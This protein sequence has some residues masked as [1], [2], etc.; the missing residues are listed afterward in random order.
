MQK[1]IAHIDMDA[2]Y[3]SIEIRDNPSLAN[4]PVA[5]GG[6]SDRRGVLSTCNYIARQYGVSSAMPTGLA[7]KKCPDLIVVPG[8]MEVY[9][10]TSQIIHGIFEKYT[11]II[12]P[13]SLDEAYL[14]LTHSKL[15]QGSATLIAQEIRNEIYKATGL[16]ASAGISSLKFVAKV[17]SDLNKP[18]GQCTIAPDQV[19]PFLQTLS[20]KKIPGVGKVTFEKL[21]ALGFE[22]CGDIRGSDEKF[23]ASQF[24]KYGH[25]L[26]NRSHGVDDRELQVTRTRKS[27]GV[28]RTFEFDISDTSELE[29]IILNKLLP[30]LS[31][32][33]S[34]Y[35]ETRGM[36][37]LGIKIKFNDFQQTT[38]DQ[39]AHEISFDLLKVLLS[40]AIARGQGK[41]IRL[42]GIHVGLQEPDEPTMQLGLGF[43]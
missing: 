37:K 3:V 11:E 16:T 43:T 22:T 4:K 5:V 8:R 20:L 24:G 28:E 35:L 39:K 12:E 13:L 1:K 42:L 41:P 9:K 30:E 2:Y 25:V 19:W 10:E 21:K 15:H 31:R 40:Q 34:K 27:V 26:W 36:N 14:D 17:A 7:L 29:A 23:L 38:K 33:S 6:K 18:N 32:R